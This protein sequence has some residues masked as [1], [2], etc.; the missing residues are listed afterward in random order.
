MKQKIDVDKIKE[1]EVSK[2]EIEQNEKESKKKTWLLYRLPLILVII[3]AI[4]Y[5]LTS[6]HLLLIPIAL[7]FVVVLYGWDC[8]SRICTNC[9]KWNSTVTLNA[10]TVLRKNQVV[11]KNLF[12]KDKTKEKKDIV[13]KT[14]YKC[15]NCGNIQEIEKIK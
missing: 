14:K 10:Q 4:I 6:K 13:N 8:H 11:Q 2:E 12:G 1:R 3:L 7:V 9:K 5:I 15:L